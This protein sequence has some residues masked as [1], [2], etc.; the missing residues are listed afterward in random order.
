MNV[1]SMA[2]FT[3]NTEHAHH[4]YILGISGIFREWKE[5]I[6]DYRGTELNGFHL[7]SQEVFCILLF[8]KLMLKALNGQRPIWQHQFPQVPWD[9]PL[10]NGLHFCI[11]LMVHHFGINSHFP[12]IWLRHPRFFNTLST[13]YVAD[14]QLNLSPVI[15]TCNHPFI[16]YL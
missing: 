16:R 4:N 15:I 12:G 3:Q 8:L 13:N 14:M 10:R 6:V 5:K 9:S 7:S 2:Q 11:P 1:V